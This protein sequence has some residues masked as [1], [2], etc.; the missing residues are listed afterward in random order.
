MSLP[1][2]F[3]FHK[4]HLYENLDFDLNTLNQ[5]IEVR[6]VVEIDH[7]CDLFKNF[8]NVFLTSWVDYVIAFPW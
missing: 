2:L 8:E 6:R 1:N 5:H 4:V 3:V 7:F